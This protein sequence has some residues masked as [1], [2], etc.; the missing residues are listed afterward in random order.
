MK[1]L[2]TGEI[3]T[4]EKLKVHP[5]MQE[6]YKFF[7]FNGKVVDLEN[8]DPNILEI[9]AKKVLQMISNGSEGW[10]N[11]LPEKIPEIIKAQKLFG[12][13]KNKEIN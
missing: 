8:Y 9:Y 4:S 10:E 6:L 13:N 1:D 3:I 11:M 2:K 5:R 7:K 12:Y